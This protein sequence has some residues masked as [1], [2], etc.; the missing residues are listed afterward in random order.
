MRED[1]EAKLKLVR[2]EREQTVARV[3]QLDGYIAAL[4]YCLT[5]EKTETPAE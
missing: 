2:V 3:H 5:L 1:I 4:E